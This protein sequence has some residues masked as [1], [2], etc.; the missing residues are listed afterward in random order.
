MKKQPKNYITLTAK[1]ANALNIIAESDMD[2]KQ[3]KEEINRLRLELNPEQ[4]AYKTLHKAIQRSAV[5]IVTDLGLDPQARTLDPEGQKVNPA[6]IEKL[7]AERLLKSIHKD[8]SGRLVDCSLNELE[9]VQ[10]N[11]IFVVEA[12]KKSLQQEVEKV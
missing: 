4:K 11:L 1:L 10:E 12:C 9:T 3:L 7:L 6:Y 8:P 5:G 2:L